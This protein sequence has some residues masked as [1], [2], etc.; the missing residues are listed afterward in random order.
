MLL[1]WV[2]SSNS[3]PRLTFERSFIFQFVPFIVE[4]RHTT[5]HYIELRISR[6]ALIHYLL[7]YFMTPGKPGGLRAVPLQVE[8]MATLENVANNFSPVHPLVPHIEL[9]S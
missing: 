5:A 9:L 3:L 1:L 8:F 7:G 2:S 4:H 6:C